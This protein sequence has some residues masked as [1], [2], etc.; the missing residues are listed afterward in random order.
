MLSWKNKGMTKLQKTLSIL[1]YISLAAGSAIGL[2]ALV[3]TYFLYK[4]VPAGVCP[5]DLN[6]PWMYTAI[7]F[8]GLSF[9]LSFFE[10]KKQSK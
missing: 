7:V 4:S 1:N 2:Y 6:R 8:L 3:N 5:I 9:I 10:P